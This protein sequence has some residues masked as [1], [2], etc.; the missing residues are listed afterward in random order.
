MK[1][2]MNEGYLIQTTISLYNNTNLQQRH[3]NA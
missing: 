1:Y 3:E 2:A